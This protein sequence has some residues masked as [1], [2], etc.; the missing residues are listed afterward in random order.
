M[1]NNENNSESL[2]VLLKEFQD[3]LLK[4]LSNIRSDFTK[5]IQNISDES[6]DENLMRIT[7]KAGESLVELKDAYVQLRDYY[8]RLNKQGSE[9]QEYL[10]LK[11]K[12]LFKEKLLLMEN[13]TSVYDS[14]S[15]S[16]FQEF[17]EDKTCEKVFLTY[18]KDLGKK[19]NLPIDKL[20]KILA[21]LD[22]NILQIYLERL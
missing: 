17:F 13:V 7:A 15:I 2:K 19:T 14:V 16:N 21:D 9:L 22:L 10:N 1:N 3:I 18:D 12:L 8:E 20:L 11:S 5:V 6:S 4:I